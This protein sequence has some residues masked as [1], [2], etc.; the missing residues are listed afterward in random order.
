M[1]MSMQY[2]DLGSMCSV[3]PQQVLRAMWTQWFNM[4]PQDYPN[5]AGAWLHHN[6]D[7]SRHDIV[8]QF[9]D[10]LGTAVYLRCSA[11]EFLTSPWAPPG[12]PGATMACFVENAKD[13]GND[14]DNAPWILGVV[15]RFISFTIGLI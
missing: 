1:L 8:F 3:L 7:F 5:T 12:Q 11:A 4:H 9:Q 13:T 15:S 6:R 10:C 14:A 2:C